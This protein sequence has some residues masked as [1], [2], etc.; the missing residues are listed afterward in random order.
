MEGRSLGKVT[1]LALLQSTYSVLS[2]P[3]DSQKARSSA[4]LANSGIGFNRLGLTCLLIGGTTLSFFLQTSQIPGGRNHR[5]P[6]TGA[7]REVFQIAGD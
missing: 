1:N 4:S 2:F 3:G 7:L 5:H 6:S